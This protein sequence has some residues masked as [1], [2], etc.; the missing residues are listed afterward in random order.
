MSNQPSLQMF[1][2]TVNGYQ[3]T[4]AIKTAIELEIFTA[5]GSETESAKSLAEKCQASERGMRIL[6]DYLTILGFLTKEANSYKLTSDSAI[7]LDKNSPAYI[8]D[9][10]EFT[11]SNEMTKAFDDLTTAVR[12]GRTTI[13]SEGALESEY[14]GWIK[15]ARAMASIVAFPAQSIAQL[16]NGEEQQHIKVLDISASHGLF[17]IAFAQRNPNA[18]IVALDWAP[19]LEVAK[20]NA[21]KAGVV[22]RYSTIAGSAFDVDYGSKYDLVLL[23]NFLHH[24]DK[25]T[26]E[27]LLKKIYTALNPTGRVITLEFIPNN[28][29]ITP[30]EAAAFSLTMLATTPSGDA[31]TFAEYETM[32]SNAGFKH[33]ELHAI[34]PAIQQV[35]ISYK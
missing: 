32:F 9:T 1:L 24:F 23:P 17:G 33:S 14:P 15:Y 13:S 8:G 2:S 22:E 28:D 25:Q 29:R 34:P 26:C 4:A 7:F 5:I 6:C 18:E 19:I 21:Q 30:P 35:V 3:R 20:E 10:I 12:Q 27:K 11:L 31:Y 16:V